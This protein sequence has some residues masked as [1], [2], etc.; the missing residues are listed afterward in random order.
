MSDWVAEGSDGVDG[1][2]HRPDVWMA[3]RKD[4]RPAPEPVVVSSEE[5]DMMAS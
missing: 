3:E 5:V 1:M 2:K 4:F